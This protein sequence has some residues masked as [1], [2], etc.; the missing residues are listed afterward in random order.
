MASLK[1]FGIIPLFKNAEMQ[2]I[3]AHAG[4]IPKEQHF[5]LQWA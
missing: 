5:F 4:R 1:V 2:F 3:S